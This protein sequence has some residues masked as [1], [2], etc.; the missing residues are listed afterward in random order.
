MRTARPLVTVKMITAKVHYDGCVAEVALMEFDARSCSQ[1]PPEPRPP[2]ATC[3]NG[4]RGNG[5]RSNEGATVTVKSSSVREGGHM[6]TRS[7]GHTVRVRFGGRQTPTGYLFE[8]TGG[9]LCL[10]LSNT[11]DERPTDHPRELLPRYQDLLDWA[12]QAGALA[13]TEAT[14]LSDYARRHRKAALSALRALSEVREAIF[15]VC[16]AMAD[17]RDM[18]ARALAVLNRVMPAAMGRR[19]LERQNGRIVWTWRR[20]PRPD[21]NRVLW[22]V[23]LA[24]AE[25]LTSSV[26]ERIRRCAGSGCAW[27]FIDRSKNQTR[28]WCDM[29]VCGN[30]SKARRHYVSVKRLR[31]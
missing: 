27:L 1:W 12:V 13:G 19:G 14:E 11:V 29:S 25:L 2:P 4:G 6:S 30:R 28:R 22:P 10:D 26:I 16:S 8:L 23:V 5:S 24:A 20:P 31:K 7:A 17:R 15:D 18:P 21:L 9:H 3:W